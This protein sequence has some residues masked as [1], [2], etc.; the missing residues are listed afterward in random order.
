MAYEITWEQYGVYRRY[1]GLLT[2]SDIRLSVEGVCS[3]A[4]FDQIHYLISDL[5]AVTAY[6]VS[7]NAVEYATAL[8]IGARYSNPGIRDAFVTVDEGVIAA[9]FEGILDQTRPF[10]T[11]VLPTLEAARAW[12]GS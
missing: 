10:P 2:N 12:V 7:R 11:E 4:R 6:D 5:L 3:D 1:W 9:V 8:R